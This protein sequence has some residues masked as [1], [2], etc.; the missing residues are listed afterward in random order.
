MKRINKLNLGLILILLAGMMAACVKGDYDTPPINVP[1]VDFSANYTI[2][3]L[4]QTYTTLD[5]IEG[6]TIIKGVIIGND[7]SGNIY[8]KLIIQDGTSGI[9]V[10]I[11]RTN[12]YTEYRLGQRVL[13]KCKG[14]YIG[15]Y[16]GLIQ[17]GYKYNGGI[18]QL[19]SILVA[20]HIFKDSLPGK[21]PEPVT[22]S[23]P[24]SIT[25]ANA[26]KVST[27]V[28]FE[29]VKFVEAG[30]EYCPQ[31]VTSAINRTI[32]DANGKTLVVRNSKY[33]S[34]AGVLMPSGTGT[35]VGIL[36][37]FGSTPQLTLRDT[38]DVQGFNG[39]GG[40][41]PAGDY[42][43]PTAGL[44]TLTSLNEN[45]A[46]V[47][48]NADISLTGWTANYSKGTRNWQGKVFT[49]TPPEQ[50]AQATSYGS[51]NT[52]AENSM[53]LI[54]PPIT[55]S[56]NLNLAFKTATTYWT[57]DG[58]S[59]WIL[60]NFNGTSGTWTKIDGL[61]LANQASST[62]GSSNWIST[63]K[64]ISSIVPSGYTGTFYIGFKYEGSMP[65]S[66]TTTYRLDDV[67]IQ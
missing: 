45:F 18:G 30:Q 12:M 9:E 8:K 62:N 50:Y 43:Y 14:M 37:V 21:A 28:R 53:W 41:Q 17:I 65:Q 15:D 44:T 34:F 39:G 61:T 6:D 46:S 63:S 7:E 5:S 64:A 31:S 25:S 2:L 47:T 22:M 19:P 60:T 54:T 24:T 51:T 56:S 13:I 4:K 59:V 26:A 10:N 42:V 35:V 27:L 33:A 48:T 11:D 3:K 52:D 67:S 55:Y 20:E 29:N 1:T 38:S 66:K 57:H 58:L 16:N 40:G 36:S 32:K 49:G 23:I